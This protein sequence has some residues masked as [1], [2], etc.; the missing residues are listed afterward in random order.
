MSYGQRTFSSK[1][2]GKMRALC[3]QVFQL[4]RKSTSNQSIITMS[5]V[6]WIIIFVVLVTVASC[7]S[8]RMGNK[9]SRG[10]PVR[11]NANIEG[12]KE[13]LPVVVTGARLK[14]IIQ[15]EYVSERWSIFA[16]EDME[17]KILLEDH[18]EGDRY[19]SR[20]VYKHSKVKLPGGRYLNANYVLNKQYIASQ[21][22]LYHTISPFWD[23]IFAENIHLIVMLT[24]VVEGSRT[25]AT[26]YWPTS[27]HPLQMFDDEEFGE[28]DK[29]RVELL[30]KTVFEDNILRR[31]LKI[32]RTSNEEE[33]TVTQLQYIGWPDHGCPS[34]IAEVLALL[35]GVQ[36]LQKDPTVPI[37]VHCSAGIG[38]TGTFITIRHV[39]QTVV[40]A[41]QAQENY[42]VLKELDS[43]EQ[44]EI[45]IEFLEKQTLDIDSV[46]RELRKDRKMMIQKE[47]QLL[48]CYEVFHYIIDTDPTDFIMEE[49]ILPIFFFV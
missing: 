38:R 28:E 4:R 33:K 42:Q 19:Y 18:C 46:V 41:F 37:V 23:M 49:F 9:L 32:T 36:V 39:L 43:E 27:N 31:D 20:F 22:P 29:W 16:R 5:F 45:V 47:E 8:A 11:M 24:K 15:S 26:R 34:E 1:I 17:D 10:K 21:A 48:F 3:E 6:V 14:E 7:S 25:K 2:T 40:K 30:E 12:E 13:E 35:Y 44:A